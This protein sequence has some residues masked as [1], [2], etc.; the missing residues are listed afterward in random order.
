MDDFVQKFSN[1]KIP[2]EG[3]MI[4]VVSTWE[5]NSKGVVRNVNHYK[6]T[7]LLIKQYMS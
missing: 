2:I 6:A 7:E 4:E 1:Y 5:Q 3:E